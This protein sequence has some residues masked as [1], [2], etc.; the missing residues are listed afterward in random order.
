MFA[1]KLSQIPVG[2]TALGQLRGFATLKDISI[3]LKSVRNIQ[4]ITKSMKMVSAAKYNKAERELRGARVYGMGA[5]KFYDNIGVSEINGECETTTVASKYKEKRLLV[6]ITSDR[7]LCGAVHSSIAKEA[8]RL[9]AEKNLEAEYKLVLVGDKA[10]AAMQQLY[11]RHVL[12]SCNEIGRLPPTFEDASI[13]AAKILSSDFKFDKGFILYNKFRSIVSYKT[14]VIPMFTLD[15]IMKKSAISLYDSVDDAVLLDYANY[16]LAQLLY[17]ALKESAASEQS[18][19]MTAMDSASKNAGE[20]IDKLT[21]SLN[22]TRQSVITRELIE[23]I[24]GAACV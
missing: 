4:K 23:I 17:Y 24:S 15:A 10:K 7:G 12:F 20:M 5:L 9:L 6:L 2:F 14:S 1:A 11:A 22:R 19:R 13:I 18:S 21:M 16:S 8:R 3:R